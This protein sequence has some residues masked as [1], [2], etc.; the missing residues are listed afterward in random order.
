MLTVTDLLALVQPLT[1]LTDTE[2]SVTV[3]ALAALDKAQVGQ[4]S[5]LASPKY[6]RQLADTQASVVLIKA[7]DQAA[8]PAN[9]VALVVDDPYLAYAR[10]SH[11]F[12]TGPSADGSHADSAQI[13][14]S[15]RLAQGVTI[16][17]FAVLGKGVEVGQGAV[18]GAHCVIDDFAQIGA[19]T[20]LQARVTV[21]HHCTLGE[22]CLVQ[23]GT[24]IGSNGFG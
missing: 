5:F 24:V 16:G 23:S 3:S 14:P 12:D 6:R 15:V 10:L 7:A 22:H 20:R 4:L 18:I 21:A 17:A 19:Q 1:P 8:C 2:K 13:D 11:L 9:C